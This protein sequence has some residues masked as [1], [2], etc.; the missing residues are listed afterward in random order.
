MGSETTSSTFFEHVSDTVQWT[1]MGTHP[2]AGLYTSKQDFFDATFAVLPGLMRNGL[3]LKVERFHDADE[4]GIVELRAEATTL[5]G[6]PFDNRYCWVCRF[7]NE[8]IVEV[9][10]YL[11]SAMVAYAIGR[12]NA[13]TTH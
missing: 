5:E 6:V 12:G 13:T 7:E 3:T 2:L 4:Y 9:R 10:A 1:V 11:D 8:V